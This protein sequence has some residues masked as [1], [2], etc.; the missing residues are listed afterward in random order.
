MYPQLSLRNWMLGSGKL[1]THPPPHPRAVPILN[2]VLGNHLLSLF[3]KQ[4]IYLLGTYYAHRHCSTTSP[5]KVV[6]LL[7]FFFRAAPM[8]YGSS[9]TRGTVGATAAGLHHSSWQRRILNPLSEAR[10]W[11]C[12]LVVPSWIRFRCA[13]T[14]LPHLLFTNVFHLSIHVLLS[15]ISSVQH[16]FFKGLQSTIFEWSKNLPSWHFFIYGLCTM[17]FSP[18]LLSLLLST[19]SSFFSLP[20]SFSFF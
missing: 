6:H 18:P 20:L 12:N 8:E 4:Q 10:D 17:A 7:Y 3:N 5:P 11:T 2:V 13:M 9:Q 16:F 19:L 1:Q 14:E 15:D